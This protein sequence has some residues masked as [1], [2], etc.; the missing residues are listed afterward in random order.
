MKIHYR[1]H[2]PFEDLAN[3]V[4]WAKSRGHILT[5]TR[6]FLDE[7]Q[8]EIEHFDWLIIMGGPMNIYEEDEYPSG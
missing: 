4:I 3:I 7:A 8:P 2:V 5:C 6:L 1:Q